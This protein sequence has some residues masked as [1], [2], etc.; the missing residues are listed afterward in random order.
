MCQFMLFCVLRWGEDEPLIPPSR[1]LRIQ[2]P[3]L[4]VRLH[5]N[6]VIQHIDIIRLTPVLRV[7]ELLVRVLGDPSARAEEPSAPKISLIPPQP[8]KSKGDT[9]NKV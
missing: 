1:P 2:P 9:H 6:R 7:L 8:R 4:L 3:T 5:L